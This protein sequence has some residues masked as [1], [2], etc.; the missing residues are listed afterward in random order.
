MKKKI[1]Q[2]SRDWGTGDLTQ[3]REITLSLDAE[4]DEL[5]IDA[6]GRCTL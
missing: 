3:K 1:R 6:G 5:K 2:L 4:P